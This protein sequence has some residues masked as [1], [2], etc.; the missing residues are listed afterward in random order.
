MLLRR[1]L[2]TRLLPEQG[3]PRC[4]VLS[5]PAPSAALGAPSSSISAGRTLF[6]RRPAR[7]GRAACE[8]ARPAPASVERM[9]GGEGTRRFDLVT[10][11]PGHEFVEDT[12]WLSGALRLVGR[13]SNPTA[14]ADA[15]VFGYLAREKEDTMPRTQIASHSH[16]RPRAPRG[17]ASYCAIVRW[18]PLD[19]E[20]TTEG[21]KRPAQAQSGEV[22]ARR[23]RPSPASA[24]KMKRK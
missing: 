20:R 18:C 4:L 22:E 2:G 10:P 3:H 16:S 1:F 9:S 19:R 8:G 24:R 5:A 14:F 6:I 15:L 21:E 17:D 12:G 23:P 13:R 11:L 7:N